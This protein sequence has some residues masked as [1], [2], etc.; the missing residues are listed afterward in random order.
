MD[1]SAFVYIAI[2]GLCYLAGLGVKASKLRDEWT[3]VIVGCIGIVLGLVSLY[4]GVPD[5]PAED[6]INAAFVGA[7][8]GLSAV[9]VDQIGKQLQKNKTGNCQLD[10]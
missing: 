6:P 3:P 4:S 1:F 2:A 10:K 5:F 9:G 8:S 7:V